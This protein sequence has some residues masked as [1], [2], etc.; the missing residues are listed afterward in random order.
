MADPDPCQLRHDG[1]SNGGNE[2]IQK[3]QHRRCF[4]RNVIE[5]GREAEHGEVTS[6]QSVFTKLGI[7]GRL[8]LVNL[9]LAATEPAGHG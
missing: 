5:I 8:E 4:T 7:A 1:V 6:E 9:D 3:F 2:A